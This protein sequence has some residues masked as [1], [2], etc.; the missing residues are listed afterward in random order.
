SMT[1]KL[2]GIETLVDFNVFIREDSEIE[3]LIVRQ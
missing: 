2:E 1:G 3:R